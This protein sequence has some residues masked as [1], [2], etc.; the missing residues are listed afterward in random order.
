M[1]GFADGVH[2]NHAHEH[3]IGY[4]QRRQL[5]REYGNW[6]KWVL[7]RSDAL[8]KRDGPGWRNLLFICEEDELGSLFLNIS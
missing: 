4:R 8:D 1:R 7:K 5:L 3:H 2:K 6:R